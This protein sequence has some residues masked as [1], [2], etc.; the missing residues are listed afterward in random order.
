ML[1]LLVSRAMIFIQMTTDTFVDV[2]V[3]VSLLDMRKPDN[4]VTMRHER[5][6]S[7]NASDHSDQSLFA[8]CMMKGWVHSYLIR[9]FSLSA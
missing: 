9:V 1:A 8:I 4:T 2:H 5:L 3:Y 6:R 7:A